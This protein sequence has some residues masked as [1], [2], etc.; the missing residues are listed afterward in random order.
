[1]KL[2]QVV[3][4]PTFIPSTGEADA[5][6]KNTKQQKPTELFSECASVP[7]PGVADRGAVGSGY[8]LQL[9]T[10]LLYGPLW[11]NR[12]LPRAACPCGGIQLELTSA[13]LR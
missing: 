1:M 11:R 2:S 8:S 4:V 10:A 3:V 13:L 7:L 6:L 9:A 5:V 12:S